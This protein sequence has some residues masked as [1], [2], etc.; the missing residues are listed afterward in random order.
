MGIALSRHPRDKYFIATKLSNF[1]PSTWP[2][3]KSIEMYRNS[4]KKL[5]TDHIDY[6]LLHGVG[7]GEDSHATFNGRYIDNGI[8]DFL[9]AER[10]AGRIRH[11]GFSYHGDVDIFNMLLAQHDKYKWDFVQIQLNYLDWEHSKQINPR[12]TNASYL[13]GELQKRNIPAVIME[14]LLGG[15]LSK[16]PQHVVTMLKEQEPQKS[17][18][19]WAFRYAGSYPDVLTVLSG[20][21]YMDHL[22]D[23]LRSFCPLVPLTKEQTDFLHQMAGV[24]CSYPTVPCNEC[25]Y[26]MPCPYGLDIPGIFGHYNKCVNQGELPETPESEGYAKARRRYLA[27]FD[28]AVAPERQASH[29]VGCGKC[30]DHCPQKIN[31]PKEMQRIDLVAEALRRGMPIEALSQT[32][33]SKKL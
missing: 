5:R 29:C 1:D 17:V 2:R 12:N 16:L 10:E 28:R 6:M 25:Q 11:L 3:E 18:A 26:C 4:L 21:T 32:K 27:S 23:N 7:M 13:Y 33:A 24:I 14:P 31:I 8:L 20:M 22:E 9:L 19:S 15:R 30:L